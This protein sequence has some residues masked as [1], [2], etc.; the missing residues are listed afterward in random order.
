MLLPSGRV[1][2]RCSVCPRFNRTRC[3]LI[4]HAGARNGF[5]EPRD[6]EPK[7]G[8][9]PPSTAAETADHHL[10]PLESPQMAGYAAETRKSRLASNCVVVDA[11]R[12]EAVSLPAKFG[13]A[14]DFE[15]LQGEPPLISEKS[16]SPPSTWSSSPYFQEQGG[17]GKRWGP[18]TS[19]QQRVRGRGKPSAPKSARGW[20]LGRT[21]G[22][23]FECRAAASREVMAALLPFHHR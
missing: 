13:K 9:S 3:S 18:H 8:L 15:K 17:A 4:T 11:V 21:K 7:S 20:G 2:T 6:R 5:A 23:G 12:C 16:F 1:N 10:N 22:W 14:G 19:E